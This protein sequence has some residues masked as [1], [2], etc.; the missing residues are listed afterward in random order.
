MTCYPPY[1]RNSGPINLKNY[2]RGGIGYGISIPFPI[3]ENLKINLYQNALI[4]NAKNDGDV[5]RTKLLEFEIGL[6]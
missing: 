6:F 5:A 2:T 3:G 1:S 4:F